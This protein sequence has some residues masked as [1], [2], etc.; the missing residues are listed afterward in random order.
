MS[1]LDGF[2]AFA[3]ADQPVTAKI[4]RK[5]P[6]QGTGFFESAV[7]QDETFATFE[8]ALQ[9]DRAPRAASRSEQHH[10]E[11]A[12]VRVELVAESP[13]EAR[14]VGVE[15]NQL[16]AVHSDGI[17]RAGQAS[18]VVGLVHC[19]ERPGLVRYGHVRSKKSCRG[20]GAQGCGELVGTRVNFDIL[21]LDRAGSESGILEVWGF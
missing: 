6:R 17:G 4:R 15:T 5:L 13:Q 20:Q 1:V 3:R 11:V 21:R 9:R 7:H 16:L 14:A 2:E 8:G 12:E 19:R 18:V 10:A